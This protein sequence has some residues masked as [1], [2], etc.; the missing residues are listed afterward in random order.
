MD[1]KKKR[2]R[3]TW[4]GKHVI[5]NPSQLKSRRLF[6]G[7]KQKDTAEKLGVSRNAVSR[8]ESG[9]TQPTLRHLIALA[10]LYECDV[11]MFLH[12]TARSIWQHIETV[13]LN[14]I[15]IQIE[16]MEDGKVP[17]MD[18]SQFASLAD[19]IGAFDADEGSFEDETEA[20]SQ[21][22]KEIR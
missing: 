20:Q 2:G 18:I 11:K 17:N 4:S 22:S 3:R 9:D 12:E 8:W 13:L 10:S 14:S 6:C 19:R 15:M 5:V 21:M 7:L 1:K 16:E